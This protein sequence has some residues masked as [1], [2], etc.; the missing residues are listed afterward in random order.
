MMSVWRRR[1]AHTLAATH[2]GDN[3]RHGL[4][5]P[6]GAGLVLAA[7]RS[8]SKHHECTRF[9]RKHCLVFEGPM[10]RKTSISL[11]VVNA[12]AAT[13]GQSAPVANNSVNGTVNLGPSF[14]S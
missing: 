4:C 14:T 13:L 1:G 9:Y 3:A 8:G 6:A 2:L 11:F 7:W 10:Q 12:S 5:G